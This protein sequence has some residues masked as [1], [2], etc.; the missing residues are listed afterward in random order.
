MKLIEKIE[1]MNA[2]RAANPVKGSEYSP[3]YATFIVGTIK[4]GTARNATAGWCNFD[5]EYRPRPGEDGA[6]AIAEIKAYADQVILST[7]RAI[8]NE[9]DIRIITEAAVPPLDDSNAA[10][11]AELVSSLTGLNDT[12]VV[13]FGT[14]AGYFSD[15]NYSTVVFGPGDI[16]R[17]HKADEYIEIKELVQGLDF[18]WK[19]AERLSQKRQT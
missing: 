17:A 6:L 19:L 18:L 16:S 1:E 12:G 14:D 2:L 3:P 10:R 4:G 8:S 13:S 5:W 11:A 7:M 9:A 15:A